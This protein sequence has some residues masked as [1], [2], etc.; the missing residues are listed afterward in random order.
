MVHRGL[1]QIIQKARVTGRNAA[2]GAKSP[3]QWQYD[4]KPEEQQHI[5]M[6]QEALS[7]AY[8]NERASKQH[9]PQFQ[10]VAAKLASQ[11]APETKILIT[12]RQPETWIKSIYNQA[13]KQ[14]ALTRFRNF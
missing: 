8:I 7:I 12:V 1:L 3:L 13:V 14:G 11:I 6:S 10:Q 9:I 5:V 2:D 4:S